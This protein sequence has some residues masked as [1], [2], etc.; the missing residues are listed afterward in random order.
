MKFA[1]ALT[2]AGA[3]AAGTAM[4]AED[5]GVK[6]GTLTCQL[7]GVTNV[8]VFSDTDFDCVYE[9]ATGMVEH[10]TADLDKVGVDLS[11]KNDVTMVWAVV[12]PTDTEYQAHQLAG[13]YV[14]AAADASLGLGA[15][16]RVLVG[17]GDE[18]FTLQPIS[19]DGIE[20]V[21]VSIGIESFELE[22][23]E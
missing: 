10:Y 21:G 20:G 17:G 23:A 15:G 2:L 4:A 7:T 14:G 19:V 18:G 11:I 8:I 16:A 5:P 6:V 9:G 3:L 1:T 22:P 13:T 12:A